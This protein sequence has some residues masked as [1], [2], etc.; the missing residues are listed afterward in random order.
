[1]ATSGKQTEN[2]AY[3]VQTFHKQ[4]AYT[5]VVPLCCTVRYLHELL[6]K[7]I[8]LKSEAAQLFGLFTG[9]LGAP[10]ELLEDDETVP[11]EQA[12]CF[13][14]WCFD[15]NFEAKA[16]RHDDMAVALLYNECR[17]YL[18]LG[19]IR[20][21]PSQ[22]QEL[23]ELSDPLFPTERQFLEYARGIEGYSEYS[24]NDCKVITAI[25]SNTYIIREGDTV[26][27]SVGWEAL[28]VWNSQVNALWPWSAVRSWRNPSLGVVGFE[29]CVHIQNAPVM[30]WLS[31]ETKQGQFLLKSAH[32]TCLI[33]AGRRPPNYLRSSG[34]R[35]E[36]QSKPFSEFLNTHFSVKQ[37]SSI[38]ED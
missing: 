18:R 32:T 29:V 30:C 23:E 2:H 31:M 6:C 37:F 8:G 28:S 25:H 26:C 19:R 1:M 15:P 20:P 33:K 5:L 38:E 14:R 36:R 4:G 12:L 7:Q 16:T 9:T 10:C 24:A 27:C 11:A 34:T 21:S 35:P 3:E 22:A 17:Y 13:Q